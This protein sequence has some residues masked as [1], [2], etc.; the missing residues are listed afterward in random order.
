MKTNKYI[1]N[2][3]AIYL[4]TDR[5]S[6]ILFTIMY[7]Y[8]TKSEHILLQIYKSKQYDWLLYI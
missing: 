7:I 4:I 8:N 1:E 2:K 6:N 5:C 3:Y